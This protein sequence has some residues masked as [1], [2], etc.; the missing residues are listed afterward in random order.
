MAENTSKNRKSEAEENFEAAENAGRFAG[1]DADVRA[2][3]HQAEE[4][5]QNEQNKNG[6]QDQEGDLDTTNIDAA[7]D[8]AQVHDLKGEAQNVNDDTGRPLTDEE[9]AHARNKATEGRRQGRA[10]RDE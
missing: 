10:E 6:S 5:I 1:N 8:E 2:A 4:N 3:R 9:A 7:R